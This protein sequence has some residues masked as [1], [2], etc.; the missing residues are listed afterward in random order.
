MQARSTAAA[1]FAVLAALA[2]TA[3][4]AV[5]DPPDRPAAE[6]ADGRL[7]VSG[8]DGD[9]AIRLV[10]HRDEL[11]VAVH[12]RDHRIALAG[13]DRATIAPGAGADQVEVG[14]L[15]DAVFNGVEIDLG[16]DG[17][18]DAVTLTGGP[19]EDF[20]SLLHFGATTFVLGLPTF[21]TVVNGGAEDALTL[22]A[23]GGD[24]QV[25]AQSYPADEPALTLEGGEGGDLLAAGRGDDLVRGGPGDDFVTGGLGTDVA[26]LG[27]GNDIFRWDPGEGSDAVAGQDG[28]DS[29]VFLGNGAAERFD[30]TAAG[31][32]VRLTR[33]V[34]GIVME[35]AG[36]ERISGFAGAG[37]DSV[38]IGD[39]SGT[40]MTGSDW[41][42]G[43][44]DGAPDRISLDGTEGD[45]AFVVTGG[46]QNPAGTSTSAEVRGLDAALL[47][48][49]IEHED[50]LA[51]D[52]RG[53]RDTLDDSGLIPGGFGLSF[54][55]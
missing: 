24:D 50:T 44:L 17:A 38:A 55:P 42:L 41:G 23:A 2:T 48:T 40:P 13:L 39:L 29:L 19:G 36:L 10:L 18:A 32:G 52:G 33:D 16:G 45:D 7:V 53:G 30:V 35:L 27:G 31:D 4:A 15:G 12:G 34:G 11:R 54:I 25:S 9:D 20:A 43:A 22:D 51:I 47:V 14:D 26:R 21:S 28:H 49:A 1:G 8:T 6:V 37:A 5:A 46:V 3:P